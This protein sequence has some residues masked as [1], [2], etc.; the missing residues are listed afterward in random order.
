MKIKKLLLF[1]V[2]PSCSNQ[3]A[4]IHALTRPYV[5]KRPTAIT[6]KQIEKKK[7]LLRILFPKSE[8]IPS[9]NAIEKTSI[10][11]FFPGKSLIQYICAHSRLIPEI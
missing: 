2:M 10:V 1:I 5:P 11:S 7:T 4:F 3:E 6:L 8:V 9:Q